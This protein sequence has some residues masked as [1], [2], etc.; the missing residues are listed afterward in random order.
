[1]KD[2]IRYLEA[3]LPAS[4]LRVIAHRPPSWRKGFEHTFLKTNQ[5]VIQET[6]RLDALGI[7]SWL[8]LA[9]Y[10]DPAGG[11]KQVNT[12]DVQS[13]W[14]DIDFKNYDSVE[15]AHADLALLEKEI[16]ETSIQVMSGG[17]LHGYWVL[18]EAM[19]TS[20]WT[21][22]ALAFQA[23]WQGLGIK[24]D[25]V[26]GDSA[27]VLRMPGSFNRKPEYDSP[28]E[29]VMTSYQDITYAPSALAKKLGAAKAKPA[30]V[31]IPASNVAIPAG[32]FAANDDLTGGL[33]RRPAHIGP[34]ITKCRQLKHAYINQDK[35]NE[36]LWFA[37]VQVARHTEEGRKAVHLC[38][39]KHPTYSEEETD[40]KIAHLEQGG[41]GPTTC[42][43][44]KQ[45]NPSGCEGCSLTITSPIQL[46][47]KDI[48]AVEPTVVTVERTVTESGE[49]VT[50]EVM[51]KPDVTIPDGFA[52]DGNMIFRR[53]VD[54][55]TGGISS[56][57]VF[58]GFICPERLVTS[59]RNN[60]ATDIQF[61]VKS[62]GQDAKHIIVPAKSMSDKKDLAREL[63]GKGAFFMP[64]HAGSIL[65]LLQRMVQEVQSKKQDSA[66]A[67][68]MGW[69]ENGMFVV[70]STGY[71]PNA[72]PQYDLPV[73]MSTRAVAGSYQSVGT[74]EKWKEAANV[75]NRKGAEA[76]Q[77]ALLYG[78]AGVVLPLARLSGVVLSL[79]SQNA[80]RGKST[81]GF[82]ALS[83]WGNPENLKSQSK[84]TNNALFNK[85]SRHKNLPIMMDEITDKP[86]WELEDIVYFMTQG[87]EKE[88]MTSDRTMRPVMPGWALPAI[89]T[90]NNSIR[91]KLQAKRGD[92][93]GLFAR[94]IEVPMDLPFATELGYTER[95]LLRH[96]F[97]ENY[98]IAGPK[99]VQYYMANRDTAVSMLD[100]LTVRFD[101]A[102][103]GD[104]A[105]R[106]WVASCAATLVVA[107]M[108]STLGLVDYDVEALTDWTE[109][110]LRSQRHDAVTNLANPEDILGQFLEVNN[111]RIVVAYLRNMG[112]SSLKPCV[113]PEDGV[114]GSQLVGRVEVEEHSLFL[115]VPAFQRFCHESGYDMA[116]LIRAAVADRDSGEPL[117]KSVTPTRV[118]LGRGTK[119]PSARMQSLD[120]NLRHPALREY[121]SGIDA[122]VTEAT[123]HLRSVK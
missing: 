118:S 35:I 75:Y 30:P 24:A 42:K 90:S 59:V 56:D 122:R 99:L 23:T 111:N 52:Y 114:H 28:R 119:T 72:A 2:A 92:A 6:L 7:Q 38:S 73:P 20:E 85:A 71:L 94:I 26:S 12:V 57:A 70:G 45:V 87:R 61:Y 53:K 64:N 78:A 117:L 86:S 110:L 102:V 97:V 115:S 40:A 46:G 123:N 68:Q 47:V 93:Q 63:T 44:F 109:N 14:I 3:V 98:G 15:A 54:P 49:V 88:S 1:M 120:F 116:S 29:V 32:L 82:A 48:V 84:D 103:G 27:R 62:K 4:G 89:S 43:H 39:L 67:E 8:A 10:A 33:N 17:G 107:K 91:S 5:E 11:R 9:T 108:A 65:E 113:W 81:A 13:L 105:Y 58:D 100:A 41:I 50:K 96:G 79:Y 101:K 112:G 80:G 22:L 51:V 37:V 16:G 55:E 83:W 18:R 104:S 31:A 66:V 60:H 95:M 76:Y 121:A 21:P 25:P 19:P 106:F 77:F 34:M 74:L 36:P 69:Q